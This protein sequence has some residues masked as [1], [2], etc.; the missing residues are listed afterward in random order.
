VVVGGKGTTTSNA[1]GGGG[2]SG[3]LLASASS[4]PSSWTHSDV[5]IIAGGGGGSGYTGAEQ[6][7][8]GGNGGGEVAVPGGYSYQCGDKAGK[9]DWTITGGEATRKNSNGGG[10]GTQVKGGVSL[11][12]GSSNGGALFGGHGK[13]PA[14]CTKYGNGGWPNAGDGYGSCGN[15][16]GGGSGWYGGGGG[17][18]GDDHSQT[19]RSNSGGGGGGSSFPK[20]DLSNVGDG[21]GCSGSGITYTSVTHAVTHG[22]SAPYASDPDYGSNAGQGGG[23]NYPDNGENG[24]VVIIGPSGK[25]T[26]TYT[27]SVQSF[28]V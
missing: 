4:S 24:R 3:L 11:E 14:S 5:V 22:A 16:G 25:S 9:N 21:C 8:P 12:G 1:A 10:P 26:F 19:T 18:N 13:V 6:G 7:A 20:A 15:G 28:T 17:T 23:P 2:F 27:G